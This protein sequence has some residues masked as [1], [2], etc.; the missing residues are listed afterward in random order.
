MYRKTPKNK[1]FFLENQ[2]I[3]DIG[4]GGGL[5][6]ESMAQFGGKVIGIDDSENSIQVSQN[7]LEQ[8]SRQLKPNLMYKKCRIE[9]LS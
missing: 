9:N 5:L 1:Y 2:N 8:N 4:C 3:L 6:S 7:H